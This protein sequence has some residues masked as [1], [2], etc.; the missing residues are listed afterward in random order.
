MDIVKEQSV[1]IPNSIIVTELSDP[2]L[3]EELVDFLNR[4]GRILRTLK[5]DD[6]QSKYHNG[7]IAEYESGAALAALES[8]LPYTLKSQ[9]VSCEIKALSTEYV[10]TV[11]SSATNSLFTELQ[12][13]AKLTGKSFNTVL[14]EHLTKCSQSITGDSRQNGTEL[15]ETNQTEPDTYNASPIAN[16]TPMGPESVKSSLCF[17]NSNVPQNFITHP[18]VQ[19]VVVEH[20]VRSEA[21]VFKESHSFRLRQF[22]GK[23]PCPSNEVDFETWRTSVELLIQ[24]PDLSELQCS[25]KVLDSLV[26]PAAHVIKPL[27]PRAKPS[28]YIELLN[29]AFGTVEDGDELFAK[30]LSTLQ[31]AG[32]KPSQYLHRLQTA[33]A[34]AQKRG[35]VSASETDQHLLRQ[36]CRGCWDNVLL[37]DLQLEK[38]K[39]NPPPFAELLL[40]LRIE[41]DKHTAKE[42]R[43]KKHFAATRPKVTSHAM[44][45]NTNLDPTL[46]TDLT[47][48]RAQ[49]TELQ[50]QLSKMKTKEAEQ[51]VAPQSNLVKEL[52]AQITELQS[53][54][55]RLK[56]PNAGRKKVDNPKA[57][58]TKTKPKVPE[59]NLSMS[60]VPKNRPRPWYCFQCGE[61][62][63]IVSACSNE[64]NPSLVAEKRAKL[65]EKQLQWDT[66]NSQNQSL[67]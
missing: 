34:K 67:N 10:T 58:K 11:T 36:F 20:I 57:S 37:A 1:K 49:M 14:H 17:Q 50:N 32:E 52:K 42:S 22:S 65:K 3:E 46:Q 61:D 55:A 38:K 44:A 63:H 2:N 35:G 25:R 33:L 62:G 28:A 27:G 53:H 29:S 30:F 6:P 59:R 45:A 40:Q 60:P 51:P 26:P 15:N 43:M 41:E 39:N 7:I 18:D 13:V 5:I 9:T 56:S 24:D 8:L 48:M 66:E 31:D 47:E 16:E 19:K 23:L 4:Y 12:E 21:P 64:S 54:L